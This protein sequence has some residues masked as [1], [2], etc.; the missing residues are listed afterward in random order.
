MTGRGAGGYVESITDDLVSLHGSTG[1]TAAE[2]WLGGL[3]TWVDQNKG[4]V[5]ILQHPLVSFLPQITLVGFAGLSLP[6]RVGMGATMFFQTALFVT[7][8]KVVTSQVGPSISS[9]SRI[10]LP[11]PSIELS[12]YARLEW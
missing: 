4:L 6:R 11:L 7:F 1:G 9:S 10:I 12:W 8:N 5:E 2:R 3:A